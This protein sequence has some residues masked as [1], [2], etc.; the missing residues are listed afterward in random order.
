ML[1]EKFKKLQDELLTEIK[2][3]YGD[4]LVSI[5]WEE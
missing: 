5:V 4:R 1:K 2:A 3:F